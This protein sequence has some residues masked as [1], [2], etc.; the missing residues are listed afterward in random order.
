MTNE[1]VI[2]V[3]VQTYYPD[4]Q[5]VATCFYSALV[6]L[7]ENFINCLITPETKLDDDLVL[8]TIEILEIIQ[9]MKSNYSGELMQNIEYP[10]NIFDE[11]L[12]I[13]TIDELINYLSQN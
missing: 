10:E 5:N 7:D 12:T 3:W 6:N 4:N 13:Y 11:Q 1:E 9:H 8:D 2:R